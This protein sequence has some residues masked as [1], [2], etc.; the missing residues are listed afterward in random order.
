M[1]ELEQLYE[2]GRQRLFG[3]LTGLTEDRAGTDVPACPDWRVR[4]VV[5]HLTGLCTDVLDGNLDGVATDPWT[6]AQVERRRTLPF[7]AVLAEWEVAGPKLAATIDDFPGWY[8]TQ[9][10]ADL[11]VHELDIVGA[12]G[13]TPAVPGDTIDRCLDFVVSAVVRPGAAALGLGPVELVAGD[14]TWLVGGDALAGS[15]A[16]AGA[17]IDAALRD[18]TRLPA[19]AGSATARVSASPLELFRAVTGRRSPVQISAFD[20]DGDAADLMPLF[21]LGPFT[22]RATELLR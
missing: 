15:D 13:L 17:A 3:V 1:R 9:V 14:H 12:L 16:D 7:D 22:V 5:A 10:V 18:G 19:P 2:D 21:G 20:W 8:G 11:T 6:A 4:D